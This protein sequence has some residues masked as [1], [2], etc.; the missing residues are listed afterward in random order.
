MPHDVF[1]KH[2]RDGDLGISEHAQRE[3]ADTE[4]GL[5]DGGLRRNRSMSVSRGFGPHRESGGGVGG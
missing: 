1:A 5:V 3:S 2:L 4:S